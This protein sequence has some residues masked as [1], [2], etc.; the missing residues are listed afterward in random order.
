MF[1][2]AAEEE[3]KNQEK[4]LATEATIDYAHKCI[5]QLSKRLESPLE[6]RDLKIAKLEAE[7]TQLK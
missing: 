2:S 1:T 6:A 5:S 7:I 4:E 3:K